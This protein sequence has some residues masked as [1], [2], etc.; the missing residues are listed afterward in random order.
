MVKTYSYPTHDT[1]KKYAKAKKS[2]RVQKKNCTPLRKQISVRAVLPS[3]LTKSCTPL[4]PTLR[5]FQIFNG[6]ET[7]CF[8]SG[9]RL[10][11]VKQLFVK[12]DAITALTEIS[13]RLEKNT[14][15]G[16][17]YRGIGNWRSCC[18][19]RRYLRPLKVEV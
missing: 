7:F 6:I 18:L 2:A 9:L 13:L 17:P 5:Q 14:S 8:N 3:C 19:R 10:D 11:K 1:Q 4:R 12:Q 16:R 15:K